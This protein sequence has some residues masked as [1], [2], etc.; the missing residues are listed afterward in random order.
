MAI[1]SSLH[2]TVIGR[3]LFRGYK[4]K[5]ESSTIVSRP[6]CALQDAS[7]EPWKS[8]QEFERE[9]E[10]DRA[11]RA[12]TSVFSSVSMIKPHISHG[13]FRIDLL[14]FLYDLEV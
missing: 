8:N 12:E 4:K 1:K 13:S 9:S 5:R 14:N 3:H 10:R 2:L 6:L 7:W 11:E